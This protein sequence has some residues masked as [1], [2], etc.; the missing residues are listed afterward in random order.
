MTDIKDEAIVFE[1]TYTDRKYAVGADT[2]V[3]KQH[4]A[5]APYSPDFGDIH[6]NNVVCHGCGAGIVAHGETGMIHDV[7]IENST[8]FHTG[9]AQD[10]DAACGVSLSNVKLQTY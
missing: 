1:T 3:K 10:I 5:A 8:I 7:V 4:T 9:T 2:G 6:I